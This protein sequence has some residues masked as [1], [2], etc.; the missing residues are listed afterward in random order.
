MCMQD[1]TKTELDTHKRLNE[2]L[3]LKF[4]KQYNRCLRL[5]KEVKD[6]KRVNEQVHKV[7][8]MVDHVVN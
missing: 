2:T 5:E 8:K 4:R 3:L 6:I 1:Y 7:I